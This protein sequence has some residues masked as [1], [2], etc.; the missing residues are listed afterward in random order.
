MQRIRRLGR[1][2]GV[3]PIGAAVGRQNIRLLGHRRGDDPRALETPSPGNATVAFKDGE[4]DHLNRTWACVRGGM[5]LRGFRGRLLAVAGGA[6]LARGEDRR[7]SES[8]S[9][10]TLKRIYYVCIYT[11][12]VEIRGTDVY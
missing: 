6:W 12:K 3:G 10:G 9:T 1:A 2:A 11:H 5:L 4:V 7:C 8:R